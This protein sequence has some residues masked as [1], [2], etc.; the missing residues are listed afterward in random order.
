MKLSQKSNS[1]LKVLEQYVELLVSLDRTIGVCFAITDEYSPKVQV[2]VSRD[3]VFLEKSP[4]LSFDCMSLWFDGY[5]RGF[6]SAVER[7]IDKE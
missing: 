6:G 2:I 1:I 7:E 3:G 4:I 5:V